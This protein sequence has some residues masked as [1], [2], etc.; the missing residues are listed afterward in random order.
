MSTKNGDLDSWLR[1]TVDMEATTR[2]TWADTLAWMRI[3]GVASHTQTLGKWARMWRVSDDTA[4]EV[5]ADLESSGGVDVHLHGSL[6]DSHTRVTLVSRKLD[7][8]RHVRLLARRRKRRQREREAAAMSRLKGV[9]SSPPNNPPIII[10]ERDPEKTSK[11]EKTPKKKQKPLEL[12]EWL[13]PKLWEDFR[14]FREHKDRKRLS[15]QAEK[16]NLTKL[17]ELRRAGNDPRAVIEQTIGSNWSGFYP[18]KRQ[19]EADDDGKK[20]TGR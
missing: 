5:V 12:P 9:S 16:V 11:S 15:V 14:A 7:S 19:D 18:V 6:S 10:P 8:A 2:G 1:E 13:D 3:M 17:K 20:W 4:R